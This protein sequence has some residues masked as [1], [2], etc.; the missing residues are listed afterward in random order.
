MVSC[1]VLGLTCAAIVQVLVVLYVM[2]HLSSHWGHHQMNPAETENLLPM[3][4]MFLLP[5]EVMVNIQVVLR[6]E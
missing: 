5:C 2:W 3:N 4:L 1:Q 6:D